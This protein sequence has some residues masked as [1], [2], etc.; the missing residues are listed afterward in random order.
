MLTNI[1]IFAAGAVSELLCANVIKRIKAL[2]PN[3]SLAQDL[4]TKVEATITQAP[5]PT[6]PVAN[7]NTTPTA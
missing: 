2:H 3:Q 5:T 4:V 1:L 7:T 6:A